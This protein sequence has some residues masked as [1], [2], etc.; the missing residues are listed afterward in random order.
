MSNLPVFKVCRAEQWEQL[1][2]TG[3]FS[4]SPDDLRDGF[5]HLSTAAQLPG[6][7]A[8]HFARPETLVLLRLDSAALGPGLKWEASR[9]AQ[10][11]PH[12]YRDL[13]LTEVVQHWTL[14]EGHD[15]PR[16]VL[17]S[18]N[19]SQEAP[20]FSM[21]VASACAFATG[22]LYFL[23]F[24]GIDIWPLSFV[25]WV[26][27][28]VALR[29][30]S[31]KQ[32]TLL[33]WISGFTM[34]F[35]GFYWLLEMLQNFSGFGVPLCLAFM[36]LLAA[37]QGGRIGLFG[38]LYGRAV[39]RGWWRGPSFALAFAVSEFTFPLLFPWYFGA[40]VH[41]VTLLTQVA[42]L[43]SPIVVG[44]VLC[45]I[46]YA[47]AELFIAH[48]ERRALPWR[49]LAAQVGVCA[50]S[51][52]YGFVRI[53]AVDEQ[54][55]QAPKGRVGIVQANMGLMEK[56]RDREGG[57]QRHVALS[58]QLEKEGPIDLI[59]WP[60]TSVAGIVR[61]AQAEL[62]YR[63]LVTSKIGVP[64]LFGAVLARPVSDARQY[65]LLNSALMSDASGALV[66]S[67]AKHKLLAFGE[68]LPLGET[69]PI[70][71]EWSPNT[72]MF[73]RGE[74][75]DPLPAGEHRVSAHICYEDVLPTY[76]NEM[77]R[78]SDADLI[79][80]MTNDAWYGDT[81]QPWIHLAL[82]TFRAIEHRRYF[83]RATNSGV[84]AFVDANGRVVSHT[85]TFV[86][87][88]PSHEVAYLAGGR[89][90]YELYGDS[91]WWLSSAA[92]VGMCL[93]RRKA[94]PAS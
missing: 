58:Q 65:A 38:F 66:G 30:R 29:G 76:V 49:L 18:E 28:L 91:P 79:V 51:L 15:L 69:F 5:I 1:Q 87:A 54:M 9:S 13:K 7:L 4:G 60:E 82:S 43:G 94:K 86:P 75:L 55:A 40:T 3:V 71:Y 64:T 59:V 41:Q 63:E 85:Q 39:A 68:Y 20:L 19:R 88:A 48:R 77:L 89:T 24:P 74:S 52:G 33:S 47:L 93:V 2:A 17:A 83:V 62:Q 42:E 12:L 92:L 81:T 32:A 56:R 45:G 10:R 73:T 8:K 21:K 26:P 14:G 23:A 44:L 6:T 22:L 57:L 70:L 61:E 11:F 84:S 35:I 50:L 27:L 72:G 31:V 36:V 53:R 34:T 25:T 46:N 67:Y 80:N 90:P 78:H 37:Y 16:D